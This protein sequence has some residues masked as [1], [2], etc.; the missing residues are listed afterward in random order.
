MCVCVREGG[1]TVAVF[2]TV[3]P[4]VSK[5]KVVDLCEIKL[6]CP[7]ENHHVNFCLVLN[8]SDI[9]IVP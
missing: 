2:T 1:A 5:A 7:H 9:S 6:S 4:V 8:F 3:S